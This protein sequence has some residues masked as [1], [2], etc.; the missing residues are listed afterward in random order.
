MRILRRKK[1]YGISQGK[2][3]EEEILHYLLKHG[4]DWRKLESE[5]LDCWK[6]ANRYWKHI[7]DKGKMTSLIVLEYLGISVGT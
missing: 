7:C 6:K 2:Q 5:Q 4:L 1:K 3:G